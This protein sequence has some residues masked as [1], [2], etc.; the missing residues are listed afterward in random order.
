[1]VDVATAIPM[2]EDEVGLRY[3]RGDGT[4]LVLTESVPDAIVQRLHLEHIVQHRRAL[5]RQGTL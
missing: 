1:M 3:Q 5:R 4:A 2:R